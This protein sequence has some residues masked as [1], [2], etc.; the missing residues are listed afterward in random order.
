MLKFEGKFVVGNRVRAYDFK[1]S[2]DRPEQ[3]VEGVI[4][5]IDNGFGGYVVK[6]ETDSVFTKNPRPEVIVPFEVFFMEFDNRISL[7]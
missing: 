6:V 2:S 5:S 3:F 1:P 4:T 7:A